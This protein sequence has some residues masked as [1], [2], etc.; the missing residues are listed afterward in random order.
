MQ[1]TISRSFTWRLL[2]VAWA[3]GIFWFSTEAFGSDTSESLIVS[4]VKSLSLNLHPN[5]LWML[6]TVL[7]KLAHLVEYGVLA[8]LLYRSFGAP[9]RIRW[10]PHAA[11]WCIAAAAVYSL[12]DEFHQLFVHGRGASLI[13]CGFD[14]AGAAIAMLSIRT[15][16]YA[17]TDI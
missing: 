9:D 12:S 17:H 5:T 1:P 7:R 15:L 11:L 2:A 13:D 3:V 6:N 10:R 4:T 16:F 8:F 14:T